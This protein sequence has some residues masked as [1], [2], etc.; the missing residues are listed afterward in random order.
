MSHRAFALGTA[1]LLVTVAGG[2]CSSSSTSTANEKVAVTASDTTCEVPTTSF[3]SGARTFTVT[4]KGSD[5]TELYVYGD[6]GKKV[7]GEV[8]NVGPG[9]SRD[10]AVTL[11]PGDYEL[12]CKPGQKGDGIRTKIK[13]TG[14]STGSVSALPKYDREVELTGTGNTFAGLEGFTAKAGETIEFKLKNT[15]ATEDHEF[16]LFAPDGTEMGEIPPIKPGETGEIILKL[17]KP[18]TY[19]YKCGHND[20]DKQGMQGTFTVA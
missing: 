18:G 10:L 1:V 13:I 12:A 8:E 11:E 20:H 5:V 2:A 9:T 7:I 17:D 3:A 19:T 14:A 6:G 15:D 4:N 16:E